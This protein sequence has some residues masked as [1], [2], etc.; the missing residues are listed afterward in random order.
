M[1]GPDQPAAQPGEAFAG[2][3]SA[4]LHQ[5]GADHLAALKVLATVR[6]MVA[7]SSR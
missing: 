5:T 1:T 2:E 4:Q 7:V 3:H 6:A